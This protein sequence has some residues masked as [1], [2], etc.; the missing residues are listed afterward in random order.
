MIN[1][2]VFRTPENLSLFTA[3]VGSGA[4]IFCSAMLLLLC[5][6][7]GTFKATKRGAIL[8]AG[9]LIYATCGIIGGFVSGRLFKQLKGTNWVW[10]TLST[11]LVFPLPLGVV[12]AWVNT[13]AATQS[14][15][16][17]LPFTTILVS[18]MNTLYI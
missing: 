5:V 15:T 11:A 16:V 14:S 18:C 4:Q 12:F 9:I 1:G 7:C 2:D 6:I 10:N 8:T 3:F 17:A 13:I